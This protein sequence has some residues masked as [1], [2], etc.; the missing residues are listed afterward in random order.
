MHT[1]ID[2]APPSLFIAAAQMSICDKYE[3]THMHLL[4][5]M[6]ADVY[7]HYML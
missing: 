3:N 7:T 2:S 1:G 4:L 6:H 5:R